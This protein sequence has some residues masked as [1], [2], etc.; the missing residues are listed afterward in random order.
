MIHMETQA[1][2]ELIPSSSH[3]HSHIIRIRI[4]GDS[5]APDHT[6][7]AE[8]LSVLRTCVD[9]YRQI[10]RDGAPPDLVADTATTVGIELFN[11][12]LSSIWEPLSAH[13]SDDRPLMLSIRSTDQEMINLPWEMLRLPDGTTVGLSPEFAVRRL[14][15]S[16]DDSA[17]RC[18]IPAS[19][20]LRI[21]LF[22]T[23]MDSGEPDGQS[24]DSTMTAP[25]QRADL[26]LALIRTHRDLH[27]EI[28]DTETFDALKKQIQQFQP[29]CVI[30]SG[31]TAVRSDN[32]F[33][34]F[35]E[36]NASDPRAANEIFRDLFD[37]SAV[38]SVIVTGSPNGKPPPVA[39][40]H[41]LADKLAKMG[42]PLAI[43]WP[44]TIGSPLNHRAFSTLFKTLLDG[45]SIDRALTAARNMVA[46][47]K[48]AEAT[49]DWT[50][51]VLFST[52]NRTHLFNMSTST[53]TIPYYP[54]PLIL[55]GFSDETLI[56][57]PE[58]PGFA[59]S[60]DHCIDALLHSKKTAL[61]VSGAPG[62]GKSVFAATVAGHL[63]RENNIPCAICIDL[64][65]RP[66][67]SAHFLDTL[68]VTLQNC[69]CTE[70]AEVLGDPTIPLAD[71]MG[72]L[73]QILNQR[74]PMTV[75]LDGIGASTPTDE[76]N[77]HPE[78]SGVLSY[79]LSALKPPSTILLTTRRTAV[80]HAIIPSDCAVEHFEIP[81]YPEDSFLRFLM[82][83]RY[84]KE[85][86]QEDEL[87][88]PLLSELYHAFGTQPGY[89][90]AVRT[91]LRDIDTHDLQQRMKE[92]SVAHEEEES[93]QPTTQHT[94][95][96]EAL[97]LSR[98]FDNYPLETQDL[99]ER[100]APL[101]TTVVPSDISTLADKPFED[102]SDEIEWLVDAGWI[103]RFE[104]REKHYYYRINAIGQ[105]W[106]LRN[107]RFKQG[108]RN[109]LLRS[110]AH[111]LSNS[112]RVLLE[113]PAEGMNI[114]KR[115]RACALLLEGRALF[116]E[117]GDF[118][119]ALEVSNQLSEQLFHAGFHPTVGRLNALL[120]TDI[121][122]PAFTN[123]MA[124][125]HFHSGRLEQAANT[126]YRALEQSERHHSAEKSISQHG[127]ALID[128]Q[129]D[130]YDDAR[131]RLLKVLD[132]QRS[133]GNL[134]AVLSLWLQ[135]AE[136]DEKRDI[137]EDKQK[138]LEMALGIAKQSANRT[139]EAE[140]QR[141]IGQHCLDVQ[142]RAQALAALKEALKIDL[143]TGNREGQAITFPLIGNILLIQED[144][145]GSRHHFESALNLSEELIPD[146]S[147]AFILH[148]LASIDL[149]DGNLDDA[150]EKTLNSL[151][152]K[153]SIKDHAGQANAFLQ[154]GR[155]AKEGGD[156]NAAL[157]L[158]GVCYRLDD[159]I[160]HEDADEGYDTF[161]SIASAL[162]LNEADTENSLDEAW[163]AYR[164]DEGRELIAQLFKKRTVIP[165]QPVN[166]V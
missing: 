107:D 157:L 18:I 94:N 119:P 56:S 38:A 153:R 96:F 17:R 85:R 70:E 129:S 138:S 150:R 134:D 84:V 132:F 15:D 111:Y 135:I 115:T 33:F 77:I 78:L 23:S 48:N 105:S 73:P 112:A 87:S 120:D 66:L 30:L 109:S 32:S 50:L 152:I 62:S 83:D 57:N 149:Q 20:P 143:E 106:L 26:A 59:S 141:L 7:G 117:S 41:A 100:L 92:I 49:F 29:H 44:I 140:I 103:E 46:T 128:L 136:I 42:I 51:P 53:P 159:A 24:V 122:H 123:W 39:S 71:R 155:I 139:A 158:V 55:S 93:S 19:K 22:A 165:I 81:I 145:T 146:H 151:D 12:A 114:S 82:E 148:Q 161:K 131:E 75:L 63:E 27:V 91:V 121:P 147:R 118:E 65:N 34:L 54:E 5:I 6:V 60:I 4:E 47:S 95:S 154:L 31:T 130:H 9:G 79:L 113:T 127:L 89:L 36:H 133:S 61:V 110:T 80:V 64:E 25:S 13:L 16:A 101:S 37:C 86:I 68:R 108:R 124:A 52:S 67:T 40:S 21:L 163:E 125:A 69:G 10:L 8:T 74:Q 116:I 72:L 58:D 162:Q 14:P 45:R 90:K 11:Y 1:T 142:R 43:S 99:L 126:Y 166:Q 2:L 156:L 160:G 98:I 3:P 76:E 35:N 164:K 97:F 144:H 137:P 28:C 88:R 102:I 104:D